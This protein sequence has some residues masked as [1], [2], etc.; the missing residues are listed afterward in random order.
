MR[1]NQFMLV[2]TDS[3]LKLGILTPDHLT[4]RA[5]TSDWSVNSFVMVVYDNFFDCA[6]HRNCN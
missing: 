3:V 2:L 4:G 5:L 1:E 6:L